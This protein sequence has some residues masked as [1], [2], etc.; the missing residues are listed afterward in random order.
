MSSES[1]IERVQ[2][3]FASL[4]SERGAL[5]AAIDEDPKGYAAWMESKPKSMRYVKTGLGSLTPGQRREQ[6]EL[7]RLEELKPD[8]VLAVSLKTIATLASIPCGSAAFML[9]ADKIRPAIPGSNCYLV[10]DLLTFAQKHRCR[11]A[12]R[13]VQ[14]V[15]HGGDVD[16]AAAAL[17]AAASLKNPKLFSSTSTSKS[18]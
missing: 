4:R 12:T 15:G 5:S 10:K 3:H 11:T 9:E 16:A 7:P 13:L 2:K 1:F 8:S 18:K 6:V 14:A 17:L